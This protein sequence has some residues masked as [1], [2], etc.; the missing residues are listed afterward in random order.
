M[1]RLKKFRIKE[2]PI[3]ISIT[4]WYSFFIVALLAIMISVSFYATDHLIENISEKELVKSVIKVSSGE[5]DFK[6][7]DDGIFFIKYRGKRQIEGSVPSAFDSNLSFSNSLVKEYENNKDNKKYIYYDRYVDYEKGRVWIRGVAPITSMYNIFRYFPYLIV[8]FSILVVLIVIIGGYKIVK[9]AFKPVRTIT[10]TAEEIGRSKDF[11]KRI[12][13]KNRKDE[14]HNLAR[15]FN[16]MLNSLEG[17]YLREKQF[18]SDVSHELRT[19]VSVIL[20]ESQYA[21][22]C[23]D[24]KDEM[25]DSLKVIN[26]QAERMKLLINQIMEISHIDSIEKIKNEDINISKDIE[27]MLEDYRNYLE[28]NKIN[29]ITDIEE[30]IHISGDAILF[31]RM[32]SNI[33]SNAIKFTKDT[34]KVSVKSISEYCLI[35]IEDNGL[36]ISKESLD[37]IWDRFYQEDKSRNKENNEGLGLGLSFVKEI[38]KLHKADLFVES[39]V[40]KY[41]RFIVKIKKI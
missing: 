22:L 36:G 9:K 13:L 17:T 30:D 4:M 28:I 8:L 41:S 20:A 10:Q 12:D 16:E 27:L 26:R 39:E 25:M 21:Q 11:S 24:D 37:K 14:V 32:I 33:L 34:I 15:V 29:I 19:P 31:R 6:A 2:L 5:D 1:N 18:S 7:F 3:T 38:S 35:E 23:E 40:G